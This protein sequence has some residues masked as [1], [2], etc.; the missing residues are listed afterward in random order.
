MQTDTSH[1]T[2]LLVDSGGGWL[3]RRHPAGGHVALGAPCSVVEAVVDGGGCVTLEYGL[4]SRPYRRPWRLTPFEWVERKVAEG[5]VVLGYLGFSLAA[6]TDVGVPPPRRRRPALPDACLMAYEPDQVR[7]SPSP[8]PLPT[9]RRREVPPRLPLRSTLTPECYRA[10]VLRVKE[11]IAAGDVYQVNLSRHVTVPYCGSPWRL[12]ASLVSVQPVPFAALVRF[13]RFDLIS[14]SMELFLH[15]RGLTIESA[16]IKG[17]RPLRPGAA[18]ELRLSPKERAENLMIV[19]LMRNDLAK[20]CEPGSVTV[21][22]LFSVKTYSTLHQMESVVRGRL[23]PWT[24]TARILEATLPPG[25]V[26]GAPKRRAVQIIYEL[27][28]HER[29]PYCGALGIFL[30]GGEFV[31]SVA[32]RTAVLHGEGLGFW[33]GGGIVWDSDPWEEYEETV[34]K[35]E[36]LLRALWAAT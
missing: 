17:T 34:L 4:G 1:L 19:D 24:G 27:E 11:L 29:G 36:A 14:N 8:P 16:P 28:P 23:A 21:S 7:V 13:P 30:P 33:V 20:V 6:V 15:R 3:R 22:E 31:L 25:S 5:F 9:L 35:A 18:D 32:I 26:T 2:G 10:A 12:L